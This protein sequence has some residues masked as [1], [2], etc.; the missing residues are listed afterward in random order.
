MKSPRISFISTLACFAVSLSF[1]HAQ[2]VDVSAPGNAAGTND[3]NLGLVPPP[4]GGAFYSYPQ[5]AAPP[6]TI[7]ISAG[8]AP[9]G[10]RPATDKTGE[11]G[12]V[13]FRDL[14]GPII[15]V[16]NQNRAV[17]I[18][19]SSQA[20]TLYVSNSECIVW[21]N[22][23][24]D[25]FNDLGSQTEIVIHRVNSGGQITSTPVTPIDG[26][27]LDTAP[28]TRTPT[29]YTLLAARPVADATNNQEFSQYR[30]AF[31][32]NL[33]THGSFI[34]DPNV[35]IGPLFDNL[36]DA[37]TIATSADGSMIVRDGDYNL[38]WVTWEPGQEKIT[39][40]GGIANGNPLYV[41]NNRLLLSN[42]GFVNDLSKSGL[43][44]PTVLTYGVPAG[45]TLL[46]LDNHTL[47]GSQILIYGVN[48][49]DLQLYTIDTGLTA[50]GGPLLLPAS[51]N[52]VTPRVRNAI[53]GSL[54]ILSEG[55]PRILWITA[56][57]DFGT[58]N[59]NGLDTVTEIPLSSKGFPMF[60]T[61][62]EC[63]VWMNA[64][65]DLTPQGDVPSAL[66]SHFENS[67]GPLTETQLTPPIIGR[68]LAA[69]PVYTPD[70]KSQGWYI[71]TFAKASAISAE[72][73]TYRLQTLES[74]DSDGD[75]LYDWQEVAL[76]TD[77]YNA[78]T[79]L[80]GISDGREVFPFYLINGSYTFEQA[81]L[82]S[83]ARGGS[84]AVLETDIIRDG[85]ERTI[86]SLST[87]NSYWIGGQGFLVLPNSREYR[88]IFDGLVSPANSVIFG[89]PW[90]T[91]FPTTAGGADYLAISTDY[92]WVTRAQTS[93]NSYVLQFHGSNP[94]KLDTDLD[95]TK[96]YDEY[97]NGSNPAIVDSFYG[98]PNL[99]APVG[100]VPFTDKAIATTYYGLVFDPEQGHIGNMTMKVSTKA[101]FSY[102]FQ[103]L[104]SS[105]K[106]SNRGQF[107]GDGSYSGPGPSGLSDVISV[108]MQYVEQSPG[109]WVIFGVMER[110]T[111]EQF[112]FELRREE[113]GKTGG[114]YPSS[115][116]FTMAIP[117]AEE[118]KTEPLGDAVV[119]GAISSKGAVKLSIYLPDGGR[120]TYKGPILE[121]D[122][123]AINAISKTGG[124]T[125]LIGPINMEST[126]ASLHYDGALRLYAQAY[127]SSGQFVS[128][129]DQQ[130]AVLGSRYIS[131]SKGFFPISG[132]T[133]GT[134]NTRYNLFGGDF[135]GTA[136]IGTW[137]ASSKINIPGSPT[138]S[139]KA[140]FSSKTGLVSF[141]YT[142][143][144][145]TIG[146]K[147]TA[148]SYAVTLQRPK[149]IRGFYID[150]FS[151]GQFT[152][153][154][155]D[156]T[157]PSITSIFPVNKTVSAA[158]T[159]YLVQ[160]NTPGAWE[161]IV[162]TVQTITTIGDVTTTDPDTGEVTTTQGETQ[163]PWVSAQVVQ[164]GSGLQGS[165]NGIVKITVQAN[166]T[167]PKL[168]QYVTLEIA[169]INHKI[170]QDYR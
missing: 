59:I 25:T 77:P 165:G 21:K 157:L 37:V 128:G 9:F 106:A 160:V 40:L 41:T 38:L 89:P 45:T 19:D 158:F 84:L 72:F 36:T 42:P 23:F 50:V 167:S 33:Q 120:A 88:W 147:T 118:E 150:A 73:R 141:A 125:T 28:L 63:V 130:R 17:V 47:P 27:L 16:D 39:Y 100:V 69:P 93:L 170:T 4:P 57:I 67:G 7:T 20:K 8:F 78:D 162:P 52:T 13:A 161:V 138:E 107:L 104:L 15:W 105:I 132:I 34:I 54:L 64:R 44:L 98:V 113:Y 90:A 96:D 164:G 87:G 146:L 22:R 31:D 121:S 26:T 43:D 75:G 55:A 18:P 80:D 145:A 74:T 70:P 134:F 83:Q 81:K 94:R 60:V 114:I 102:S 6:E 133:P 129:I 155:N 124:Q 154:K 5:V 53:D 131:P 142:R 92:Q 58:G 109:L 111:G 115:G 51:I 126:R 1:T 24:E 144:D 149:Q 166:P 156:G 30:I 82:D 110:V 56:T 12:S 152:V 159:E 68:H 136:E 135:D 151:S 91:G 163:V 79:D 32:G 148:N 65:A 140:K 122:L 86:G 14:S 117:Q 76:S 108:D 137:D 85:T 95:G 169:G 35:V 3:V 10:G 99:P 61:N 119:T 116:T 143:T 71:T 127:L 48:G 97:Y 46:Q 101:S 123:L 153:N 112:G 2:I 29:G 11:D 49:L 139:S 66:I 168:W 62:D 103:G